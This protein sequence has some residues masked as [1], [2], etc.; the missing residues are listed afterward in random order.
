MDYVTKSADVLSSI[1]IPTVYLYIIFI[2]IT[3]DTCRFNDWTGIMLWAAYWRYHF[4]RVQMSSQKVL[5][6]TMGLKELILSKIN[7][8]WMSSPLC[9]IGGWEGLL[10]KWNI[11]QLNKRCIGDWRSSRIEKMLFDRWCC[12]RS[13]ASS[14]LHLCSHA[15]WGCNAKFALQ[16]LYLGDRVNN[17]E[18]RS[19]GMLMLGE[20]FSRFFFL[21]VFD[22]G[23]SGQF[24]LKSLCLWIIISGVQVLQMSCNIM[25]VALIPISLPNEILT[26][27]GWCHC[28][29]YWEH[30]GTINH[31]ESQKEWA[32]T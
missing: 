22:V 20:F 3:I 8:A 23:D 16:P 2:Q 13:G 12:S 24:A 19:F 5:N 4:L 21:G 29:I 25:L 31:P 15:G 9:F 32:L 27:L 14:S 26:R 10:Q 1:I 7:H 11:F 30:L 6:P 28:A 18:G 17:L